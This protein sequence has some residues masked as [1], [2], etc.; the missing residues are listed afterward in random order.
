[1][2]RQHFS[3]HDR[4]LYADGYKLAMETISTNSHPANL[5]TTVGKL[6]EAV[7]QL[8]ESL[9]AIGK[10]QGVTVDCRRGCSFCCHQPVF[11]VTHEFNYL[12][13]YINN[14]FS[15]STKKEIQRKAIRKNELVSGLTQ[16]QLLQHRS[17]CP[18]LINGK[19]SVYE[20][21]PMACRIYLSTNVST[22]RKDY[23]HPENAEN[24]PALLD[25]PLRAGR[26]LDEGFVAGLKTLGIDSE[27]MRM[28]EGLIKH[29]STES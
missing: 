2:E 25:F 20:A 6:Y 12:A 23:E 26:M 21:R 14:H 17:P 27:E 10:K 9:L 19:C 4:I 24:F 8:L 13:D 28:E 16:T 3:E 1:M 5:L 18:L 11:C 15:D 29:L 7:D 22:C